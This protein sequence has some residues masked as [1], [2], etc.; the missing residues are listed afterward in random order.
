MPQM[1]PR[2]AIRRLW[3]G[4]PDVAALFERGDLDGLIDAAKFEKPRQ[5]A[6]GRKVDR[7][8][9]VREQAILALGQIGLKAGRSAVLGALWD[10]EDAVRGAAVRVLS[11]RG[12][13]LALAQ[14]LG[15]LP[16]G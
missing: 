6:D 11:E 3:R 12:D 10:P 13:V 16:P 2:P 9:H 5:A 4:D 8:V 7:G 1:E 15:A 14:S